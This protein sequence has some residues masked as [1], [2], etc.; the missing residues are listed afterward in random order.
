M[1][2]SAADIRLTISIGP[3]TSINHIENT[4]PIPAPAKSKKI[5]RPNIF[6]L[7]LHDCGKQRT[8]REKKV[9]VLQPN[10]TIYSDKEAHILLKLK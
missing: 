6:T 9:K 8:T 4:A 1:N 3:S 5:Y 7:P 10:R 2:T